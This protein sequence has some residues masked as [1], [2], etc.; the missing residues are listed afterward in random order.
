M[1]RA[2][3]QQAL[4]ALN[5]CD[6]DYDSEEEPYK[7]FDE[8]LVNAAAAALKAALAKPEQSSYSDIVSD[9]GL[10][11]RNKFDAQPEQEPVAWHHPDCAG[12]CLACLIELKVHEEYGQ[13]GLDYLRK[14]VQTPRTE[15]VGLTDEERD[16]L[17]N[18]STRVPS[19]LIDWV[20]QKLKEKNT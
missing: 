15:W 18:G 1:N 4:D 16:E 12:V 8:D 17:L 2:I 11:P 3:M 20:E 6:W 14:R 13:Q 9:G 7:T 10:D 19:R 5:T